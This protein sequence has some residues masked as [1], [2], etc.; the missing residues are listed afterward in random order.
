VTIAS[1]TSSTRV[2]AGKLEKQLVC[3]MPEIGN[4]YITGC[5]RNAWH[6]L[7]TKALESICNM[8][9]IKEMADMA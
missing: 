9:E 4:V 6:S 7:K 2:S 3:G 8:V 1:L 5:S